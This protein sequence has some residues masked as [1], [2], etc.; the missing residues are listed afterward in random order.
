VTF[1][2][3]QDFDDARFDETMARVRVIADDSR[4][5]YEPAIRVALADGRILEWKE[6][7]GEGAYDLTWESAVDGAGRLAEEAGIPASALAALIDAV[8][9]VEDAPSIKPL[10]DRVGA[11]AQAAK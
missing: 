9:T 5:R 3:L 11:L 4:D 1:Q 7:E 2:A 8:A 6:A 10:M